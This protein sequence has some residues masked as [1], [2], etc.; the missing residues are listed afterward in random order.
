M[1]HLAILTFLLVACGNDPNNQPNDAGPDSTSDASPDAQPNVHKALP[2]PSIWCEGADY[3]WTLNGDGTPLAG[4]A[5]LEG[6]GFESTDLPTISNGV[7]VNDL[8]Q[9]AVGDCNLGTTEDITIDATNYG[10]FSVTLMLVHDSVV[11]G[12]YGYIWV[13][14]DDQTTGSFAYI[15]SASGRIIM[16]T[17]TPLGR[18]S[19]NSWDTAVGDGAPHCATLVFD[20]LGRGSAVYLDH[21]DVT[22]LRDVSS[23]NF[24]AVGR[25]YVGS[26]SWWSYNATKPLYRARIDLRSLSLEEHSELCGGFWDEGT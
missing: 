23:A 16:E 15:G 14:G 17:V 6:C 12:R 21:N 24:S 18:K 8:E 7:V 20:L 11:T 9:A 26:N 1:R 10:V 19:I 22:L 4:N 3:C 13:H 2:D 5:N 25:A